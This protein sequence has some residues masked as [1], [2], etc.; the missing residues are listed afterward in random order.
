MPLFCKLLYPG[1]IET[2]NFRYREQSAGK[3]AQIFMLCSLVS[4]LPLRK[5][6]RIEYASRLLTGLRSAADALLLEIFLMSDVLRRLSPASFLRRRGF[7]CR[8]YSL[9]VKGLRFWPGDDNSNHQ[10]NY[11]MHVRQNK[12]VYIQ[13]KGIDEAVT[14]ELTIYNLNPRFYLGSSGF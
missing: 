13:C 8:L 11:K 3:K 10:C 5:A 12:K 14:E 7:C 9:A 6:G 4:I 1:N 2:F